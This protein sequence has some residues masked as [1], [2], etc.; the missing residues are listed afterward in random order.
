MHRQGFGSIGEVAA[1][2]AILLQSLRPGGT[3]IL[4]ADDPHVMEMRVPEGVAVRSFG[5]T[6]GAD[7][8]ASGVEAVWPDRLR[9]QVALAGREFG[10]KTRLVG[11]CWTPSVQAA[12]VAAH[13]CG[14]PVERAVE[15]VSQTEP[16]T[17]RLEPVTLPSGA[18]MLRDDKGGQ[19]P[20]MEPALR[21]LKRAKV[22]RRVL[23][24]SDYSD[25]D[26][27]ERT[28]MKELGR[29]AARCADMGV[30][31]DMRGDRARKAAVSAGM[32]ES[33]AHCFL[34]LEDCAEFLRG[35]LRE[36]DLVLLKGRISHHLARVYF[37]QFGS[38]A[39]WKAVCR[40]T[41]MCD[42]CPDLGAVPNRR[43]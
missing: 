32:P 10:V 17:A 29:E 24:A 15:A 11:E 13:S 6:E 42:Q 35:E 43:P 36:G 1:E 19:S 40:K 28:R 33:N 18:V 4:N 37:A 34:N 7:C 27:H 22:K 31:V 30:F 39:C 14:V 26:A 12:L 23:V 25:A 2:K 20:T 21:V 16:F 38:V 5:L 8:R 41:S 3:A 9:M